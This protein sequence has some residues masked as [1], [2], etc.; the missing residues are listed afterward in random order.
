MST[1]R[2]CGAEILW[3]VTANGK[4]M[5][6]DAQPVP[7][8]FAIRDLPGHDPE[9]TSPPISVYRSHFATCPNADQHRKPPVPAK[10]AEPTYG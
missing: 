4:R 3:A 6:L 5:P 1:C 9:A 8:L 10:P 7:G 2:S